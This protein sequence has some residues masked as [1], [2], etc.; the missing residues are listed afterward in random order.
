MNF[1]AMTGVEPNT[2][3]TNEPAQPTITEPTAA[4]T[5]IPSPGLIGPQ[6]AANVNPLTGLMVADPAVLDRRPMVVTIS[7]AP[8][9]VRP[10]SGLNQADMVYE[11]YVE[12]GLTRFSAIFYSQ[13]PTRV[14]SIRSARL[15][16]YEL[17]PMYN[18]L[19]AYSGASN[20]VIDLLEKSD[21]WER[22]YVGI[23]YGLPYYWRD[24]A[25]EVPHNLFLNTAALWNLATEEGLNMRPDLQGMTF[26]DALPPN[27]EGAVNT[28]DIRYR[29]TRAIWQ[30]DAGTGRYRRTTDGLGH[31]DAITMEQ[32]TAANVVVVYANHVLSDIVESE[33]QGSVTYGTEIELW[34]EGDAILF[35]D[36][37]QYTGRWERP[38]REQ[39]MTFHTTDGQVLP[40]KPGNTWI[41]VFPLPQQ[42]DSGEE[43]IALS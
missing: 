34:F 18:A 21:F 23:W 4:P 37:Q 39:M 5:L 24:E 10:Q 29:A 14:G 41:Q 12:G 7:N 1:G 27:S 3:A 16:D 9:M 43:M 40:L 42:Q 32:V 2:A 28:I 17:V 26:L 8:P 15:I 31:Y 30:Y 36:G 19:L 35:R 38:A 13:S 22:T 11:H 6:F 33:W 20:A 25:I